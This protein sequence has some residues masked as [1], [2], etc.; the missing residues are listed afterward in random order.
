[1]RSAAGA[2]P[3]NAAFGTLAIRRKFTNTT[4][5]NLTRLRFRVVTSRPRR[6]RALADLRV[7]GG[8]G[9]FNATRRRRQQRPSSV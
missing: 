4:T 7:L 9:N 8:S 5:A 6:R 3:T 2:N 1:V